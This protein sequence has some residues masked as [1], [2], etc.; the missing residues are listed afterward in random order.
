MNDRYSIEKLI[1]TFEAHAIIAKQHS[2]ALPEE[3]K[4]AIGDWDF[5]LCLALKKICEEIMGLK[6]D[7]A[8]PEAAD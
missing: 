4:K 5:N 1:E 2:D 8:L 7:S 3:S 6:A